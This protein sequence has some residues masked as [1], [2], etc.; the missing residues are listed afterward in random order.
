MAQSEA[1]AMPLAL[2]PGTTRDGLMRRARLL[3]WLSLVWI[4]A[5]GA[6][7]LAAGIAAGSVALIGFGVDSVIEGLASVAIIW[8]FTGRRKA[9]EAAELR[10]QRLVAL[11]FFLLAPYVGYQALHALAAGDRPDAS[12]VGIALALTSA[13]GMPMLGMAK[14]RIGEQLGSR[15]TRGEGMQNLLCGYL[16]VALLAGL[17]GNAT[18]GLWWLDPVAALVIAAVALSE[19]RSAW[20]GAACCGGPCAGPSREAAAPAGP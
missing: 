13:I 10:A 11:Q 17:L 6:V 9:S 14:R 12:W 19:G 18:L 3:S 2:A 8:R 7:A 4:G 5:E 1:L 20:R 15:A 16:A